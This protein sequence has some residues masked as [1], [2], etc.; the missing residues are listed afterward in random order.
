[1]KTTRLPIICLPASS[2]HG[3]SPV[4]IHRVH[5]ADKAA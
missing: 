2:F 4:Y 1:M 3:L 5:Y